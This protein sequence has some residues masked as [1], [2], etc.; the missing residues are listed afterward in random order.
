[1][2]H[3]DCATT[4]ISDLR[5]EAPA[6]EDSVAAEPRPLG[7]GSPRRVV[8]GGARQNG[9]G[10]THPSIRVFWPSGN[11]FLLSKEVM[12]PRQSF[13]QAPRAPPSRPCQMYC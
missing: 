6:S 9:H 12:R 7:W 5:H 13:A 1:M 2:I 10:T 8:S 11:C 3:R 4:V